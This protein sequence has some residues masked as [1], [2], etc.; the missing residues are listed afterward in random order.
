MLAIGMMCA[1]TPKDPIVVSLDKLSEKPVRA[2]YVSIDQPAYDALV[3]NLQSEA[4]VDSSLLFSQTAILITPSLWKEG[5]Y[6]IHPPR[7]PFD[8]QMEI[9]AH[10][11]DNALLFEFKCPFKHAYDC[12]CLN[13]PASCI[14]PG[15]KP[16]YK[17][18]LGCKSML[19]SN[20]RGVVCSP[21]LCGQFPPKGT[22]RLNYY[23]GTNLMGLT[24]VL[25]DCKCN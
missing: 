20:G 19:I 13:N 9:F 5:S 24:V 17:D 10:V 18:F 6:L 23:K 16:F 11:S 12:G 1:C 3:K 4:M 2:D 15:L 22:C 21:L 14:K 8:K 25:I 7:V